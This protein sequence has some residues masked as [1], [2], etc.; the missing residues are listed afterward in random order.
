MAR[1]ETEKR[2]LRLGIEAQRIVIPISRRCPNCQGAGLIGAEYRE[3][4]A[5]GGDGWKVA[6]GSK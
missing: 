3:C 1:S 2:L 5:C 4:P 6:D